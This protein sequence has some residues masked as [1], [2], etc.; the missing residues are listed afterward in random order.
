MASQPL[1]TEN[2]RDP[3]LSVECRAIA[4]IALSVEILDASA[5]GVRARITVPLPVGAM[6]KIGL[7]G[8]AERHARI[9]WARDG[10]FGCEFMAPLNAAE[11]EQL[12]AATPQARATYR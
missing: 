10:V 4:R 12:L 7:P 1:P 9:A 5:G 11:L 8:G 6:L 3:R 2:R